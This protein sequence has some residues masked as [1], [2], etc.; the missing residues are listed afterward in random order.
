MSES[1]KFWDA[2]KKILDQEGPE[3]R[4]EAAV[5]T[6]AIQKARLIATTRTPNDTKA[7]A[8]LIQCLIKADEARALRDHG[9][10][11]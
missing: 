3:D 8:G 4:K 6:G 5:L 7:W 2:R 10:R 1:E 9:K 11:R